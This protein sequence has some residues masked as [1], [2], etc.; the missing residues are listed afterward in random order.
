LE[1]LRPA[2]GVNADC[3]RHFRNPASKP[4]TLAA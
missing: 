3:V 4:F 2:I 1:N